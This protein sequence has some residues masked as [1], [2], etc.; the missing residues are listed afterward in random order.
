MNE[1]K[2][3]LLIGSF[4]MVALARPAIAMFPGP[5]DIAAAG[6]DTAIRAVPPAISFV[7]SPCSCSSVN[8]SS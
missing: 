5:S 2:V 6:L 8:T 3:R 1:R 7:S 4:L